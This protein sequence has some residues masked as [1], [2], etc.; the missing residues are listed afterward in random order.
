MK[1]LLL[2]LLLICAT[3]AP[4]HAQVAVNLNIKRRVHMLYEPMLATVS[5]TNNSGRELM[6]DDTD[7]GQWFSFAITGNEGRVLPPRN[8]DYRLEPLSLP[9]GETL[10]RTVNL[11]ELYQITDY[12]LH[13]VR[14]SIFLAGMNKYFSSNAENVEITEGRV[15]WKQTVGA[16]TELT[17]EASPRTFSLLTLD[18]DNGTHLYVRVVGTEND[19]VYGCYSLG[20]LVSGIK[21]E[22]HF[23]RGNNLWVLQLVGQKTYLLSR[24]GVNG[25]FQAQS[26]YITPKSKPYLRKLADGTLQIVGAVR[27]E[28]VAAQDAPPV[29]K[30]SDR[31]AG[32][33][34]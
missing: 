6:L 1:R 11:T 16:P 12:G 23:D 34:R 32:L 3:L 17:E 27:Q 9:P 5:I 33:P 29:P 20:K 7:Q 13:K 26:T 19:V 18:H 30:L 22:T 28:Q 15:I 24:V 4:A 10:K 21:P 14:A 31:P 25:D 8:P 2:F